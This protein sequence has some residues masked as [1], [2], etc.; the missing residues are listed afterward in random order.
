MVV[1]SR[2][3][4]YWSCTHVTFIMYM[5]CE[6]VPLCLGLVIYPSL[7]VYILAIFG[8]KITYYCLKCYHIC[9][10]M[11][12][13]LWLFN[14]YFSLGHCW[15]SNTSNKRSTLIKC[16]FNQCHRKRCIIVVALSIRPYACQLFHIYLNI[17]QNVVSTLI[18]T[19][20]QP[21]IIPLKWGFCLVTLSFDKRYMTHG[22][23]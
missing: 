18:L 12:V 8:F 22:V 5:R 7:Q 23:H 20:M 4:R 13:V 14:V 6:Y 19:H 10:V 17:T 3:P 15:Q 1:D 11:S 21:L 9:S 2:I 16:S